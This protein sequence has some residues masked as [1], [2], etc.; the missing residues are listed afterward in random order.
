MLKFNYIKK[1]GLENMLYFYQ[2]YFKIEKNYTFIFR[3]Q[4]PKLL[5][6]Y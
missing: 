2:D 1:Y 4:L 3:L 6:S 5:I